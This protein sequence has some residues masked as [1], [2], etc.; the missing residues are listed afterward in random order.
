MPGRATKTEPI[1]EARAAVLVR[2]GA[3]FEIRCFPVRPPGPG[4]VLVHTSCCTVCGSDIHAWT[5]RR[6]PTFLPAIVIG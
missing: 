4:E 5:G 3:S 1:T 6:P 2:P